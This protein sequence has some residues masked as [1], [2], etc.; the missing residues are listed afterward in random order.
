MTR[1]IGLGTNLR[2]S[3][4]V[5]PTRSGLPL[6]WVVYLKGSAALPRWVP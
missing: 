1:A 4:S 3:A 5:K 6:P 2:P